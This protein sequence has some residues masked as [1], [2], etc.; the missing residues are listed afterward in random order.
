[1]TFQDVCLKCHNFVTSN[2]VITHNNL[3]EAHCYG[4]GMARQ[5]LSEHVAVKQVEGKTFRLRRSSRLKR[6]TFY[7]FY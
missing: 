4:K 3:V 5:F 6:L 2:E 1:M 7:L